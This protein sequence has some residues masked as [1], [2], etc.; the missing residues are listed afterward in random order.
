MKAQGQF[1][2]QNG[3]GGVLGDINWGPGAENWGP[4][5]GTILGVLAQNGGSFH[6]D[7]VGGQGPK[8]GVLSWGHYWGPWADMWGPYIGTLMDARG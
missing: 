2:F 4:D 1:K 5:M 3:N 8:C 7:I 6:G